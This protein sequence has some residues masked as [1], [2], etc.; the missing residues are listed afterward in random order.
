MT[1]EPLVTLNTLASYFKAKQKVGYYSL[2]LDE[3][4]NRIRTDPVESLNILAKQYKDLGLDHDLCF[5]FIGD[6]ILYLV[7]KPQ[8]LESIESNEAILRMKSEI[9]MTSK[10]YEQ[11]KDRAL[12]FWKN[13]M[14]GGLEDSRS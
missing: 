4:R 9:G 1:E 5:E 13:E 12:S 14:P 6:A 10:Y 8:S 7:G 2:I 3:C 11:M